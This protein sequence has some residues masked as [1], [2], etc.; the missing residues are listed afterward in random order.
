LIG[1]AA[2]AT[3]APAAAA[4]L[5]VAFVVAGFADAT[6]VVGAMPGDG[7]LAVA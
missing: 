5:F 4:E 2:A 6:A 1:G 3:D 7:G